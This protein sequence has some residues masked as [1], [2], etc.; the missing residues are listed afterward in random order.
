MFNLSSVYL[1][2][3]TG[4]S[5][6]GIQSLYRGTD[7]FKTLS[8]FHRFESEFKEEEEERPP[9]RKFEEKSLTTAIKKEESAFFKIQKKN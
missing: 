7:T 4:F 2:S 5:A 6:S 1:P 9:Q 3:D 8:T